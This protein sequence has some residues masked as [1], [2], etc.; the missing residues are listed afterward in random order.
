MPYLCALLQNLLELLL[1][2]RRL[3]GQPPLHIVPAESRD[4][5]PAVSPRT[6]QPRLQDE[7]SSQD[8]S[9]DWLDLST[10]A[11]IPYQALL[12]TGA[13]AP[14]PVG[15]EVLALLLRR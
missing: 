15:F 8:S 6:Q 13:P 3:L 2:D 4:H 7:S 9:D 5:T 11:C 14:V 1:T 10:P 12:D